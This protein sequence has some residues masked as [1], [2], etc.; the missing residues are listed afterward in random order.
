MIP[1]GARHFRQ[2]I[3]HYVAHYHREHQGIENAPI[4]GTPVPVASV[5]FEGAR[6]VGLLNYYDRAA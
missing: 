1:L 6:L 4:A 3:T 5:G 2:A